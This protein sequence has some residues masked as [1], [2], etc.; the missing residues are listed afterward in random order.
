[1]GDVN[2]ELILISGKEQDISLVLIT[3][4]TLLLLPK[5]VTYSYLDGPFTL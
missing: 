2:Q 5:K 1:M 4:E 3:S